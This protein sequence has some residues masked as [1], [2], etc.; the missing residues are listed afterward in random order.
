[1]LFYAFTLLPLM[2][3]FQIVCKF[4]DRC[5]ASRC[6]LIVKEG[7]KETAEEARG[8]LRAPVQQRVVSPAENSVR[9]TSTCPAL[10]SSQS[11]TCSRLSRRAWP[12]TWFLMSAKIVKRAKCEESLSGQWTIS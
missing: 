6:E 9:P 11:T 4:D 7:R 12:R 10:A 5:I 2:F 3:S 8:G 1:M